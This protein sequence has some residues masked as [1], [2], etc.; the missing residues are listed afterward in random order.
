M[1]VDCFSRRSGGLSAF[2]FLFLFLS[3]T[4]S[5]EQGFSPII[6]L[7]GAVSRNGL[8]R[9]GTTAIPPP[10]SSSYRALPAIKVDP[11][12]RVYNTQ[13]L[14]QQLA[15]ELGLPL[16]DLRVVDPSYPNQIQATF[17]SRWPLLANS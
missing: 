6:D 2:L 11:S 10:F 8:L 16:R 13:I 5:S 9:Q 1:M 7:P 14:K 15:N 17:T 12:G 4:K 3:L